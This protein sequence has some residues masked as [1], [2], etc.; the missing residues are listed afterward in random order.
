MT[1]SY[2]HLDV[3]K[4]QALESKMAVD[5]DIGGGSG[6]PVLYEASEAGGRGRGDLLKHAGHLSGRVFLLS[7][8]HSEMWIRDRPH[9]EDA[10][11]IREDE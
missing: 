6:D 11:V 2:T 3:Y 8:I 5:P 9:S 1:V 10:E 4:R 7:L